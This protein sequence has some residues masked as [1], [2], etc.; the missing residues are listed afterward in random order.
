M[1][2]GQWSY[3]GCWES[4]RDFVP[5]AVFSHA[6]CITEAIDLRSYGIEISR[7]H[8]LDWSEH[9]KRKTWW[10]D[11]IDQALEIARSVR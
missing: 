9:L 3:P 6:A 2:R 11:E 10:W 8:E 4:D 7:A 5:V 1:V